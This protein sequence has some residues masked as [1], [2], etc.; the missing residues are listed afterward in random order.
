MLI[1]TPTSAASAGAVAAASAAA[2]RN[3]FM[4]DILVVGDFPDFIGFRLTLFRSPRT[5]MPDLDEDRAPLAAERLVPAHVRAAQ[6]AAGRIAAELILEH[7]VEHQD[8]LAT[9][10]RMALEKRLRLP[11]H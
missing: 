11:A 6:P 3:C 10:M 1:E 9:E 2:N 4:T 8:F 7:A 5:Q